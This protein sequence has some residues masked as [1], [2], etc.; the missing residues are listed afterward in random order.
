MKKII[1][2]MTELSHL[3]SNISGLPRNARNNRSIGYLMKTYKGNDWDIY[4]KFNPN[5]YNRLK[6]W[7]NDWMNIF[8]LSW[9]KGQ[10]SDEHSHNGYNCVYRVLEG[11]FHER[12]ITKERAFF[13]GPKGVN[14]MDERT[15]YKIEWDTGSL[16]ENDRH[17]LEALQENNVSLHIYYK[18]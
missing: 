9:L 6:V 17:S 11:S 15:G 4:R 5:H 7:E 3:I 10:K 1:R 2:P 8:I 13:V 18:S 16:R 14:Y 12:L